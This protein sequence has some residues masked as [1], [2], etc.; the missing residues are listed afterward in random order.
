[1]TDI[2]QRLETTLGSGWTL[3]L[4]VAEC[5]APLSLSLSFSGRCGLFLQRD[6]R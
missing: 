5:H 6:V 4:A 3:E 2:R 1:M